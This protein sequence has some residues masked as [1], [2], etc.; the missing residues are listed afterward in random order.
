MR[1]D[2][3]MMLN[4]E[5][6]RMSADAEHGCDLLIPIILWFILAVIINTYYYFHFNFYLFSC[7]VFA[8]KSI[9]I[10]AVNLIVIY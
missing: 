9:C 5:P 1:I 2:V 10:L 7:F 3:A 8:D 4:V 6:K